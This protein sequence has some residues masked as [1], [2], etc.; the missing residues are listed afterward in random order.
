MTGS[1]ASVEPIHRKSLSRVNPRWGESNRK[2]ITDWEMYR[3][4]QVDGANQV[5]SGFLKRINKQLFVCKQVELSN[6]EIYIDRVF[7]RVAK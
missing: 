7:A 6:I 3:F 4:G 1:L 2:H 5:T